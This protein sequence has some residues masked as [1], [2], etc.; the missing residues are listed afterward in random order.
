MCQ[1]ATQNYTG[2]LLARFFLGFAEAGYYPGVLYGKNPV[3]E[4]CSFLLIHLQISSELLVP[5]G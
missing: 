2:M 5:P 3:G 1:G 4:S